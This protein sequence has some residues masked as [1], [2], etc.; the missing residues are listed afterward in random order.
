MISGL[1]KP[2]GVFVSGGTLY[3][4]DQEVGQVFSAP[5]SDPS[6]LTVFAQ[7][8]DPDLLCAGP[9]GS[10]FTGSSTG[11]VRQIGADGSVTTPSSGHQEVRGVAYDAANTRLF[12]VDH[13][14]DETDGTTNY[15]QIVPV[16]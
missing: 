1:S 12:V 8:E 7:V 15:L 3:V 14:G 4:A 16:D 10:L 13:D 5:L 11:D 6:D 9:D 2:V